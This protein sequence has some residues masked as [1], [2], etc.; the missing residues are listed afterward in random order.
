MFKPQPLSF[1][2][3]KTDCS[4]QEFFGCQLAVSLLLIYSGKI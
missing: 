1:T 2:A 4:Y 3:W